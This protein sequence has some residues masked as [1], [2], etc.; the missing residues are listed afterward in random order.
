MNKLFATLS[1]VA[2]LAWLGATGAQAQQQPQANP[3]PPDMAGQGKA[4]TV[5]ET[6]GPPGGPEAQQQGT[7]GQRE[8]GGREAETTG[9]VG[10]VDETRLVLVMEGGEEYTL[11]EGELIRD[12][13]PGTR[14]KVTY[15]EQNGQKMVTD[16]EPAG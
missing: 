9:V 2:L 16:I 5:G 10:T 12:L 6:P 13:T 8:Q 7:V 4:G 3:L 14:V 1:A 15:T 11:A